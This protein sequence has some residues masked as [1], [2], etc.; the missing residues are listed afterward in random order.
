MKKLLFLLLIAVM[1]CGCSE[2]TISS[3]EETAE[4]TT[5]SEIQTE[6]ETTTAVT[7]KIP[8]TTT[9]TPRI[10]RLTYNVTENGISLKMDGKN[11]QSIELGYSPKNDYI[12]AADFDFDGYQDIFIPFEDSYRDGCYYRYNP[13]TEQFESWDKLDEI[14]YVMET[15]GN[16]T[17][18]LKMYSM[19]GEKYFTYKWTN[20]DPCPVL[21]SHYYYTS[22]GAVDDY[23]EYTSDGSRI[24]FERHLINPSNGVRYK[25]Y[26]RDELVYFS[27]KANGIDVLRDGKV[28]QTIEGD[29]LCELDLAAKRVYSEM[30]V[31]EIEYLDKYGYY[32]PE[33]FLKT[34][35]FDFDGFDDLFIPT[36]HL[37]DTGVYYRFDPKT[38][39]FYEWEELNQIGESVYT[40][41]EDEALIFSR[42]DADRREAEKCVYQWENDSLVRVSRELTYY[43][44]DGELYTDHFDSTDTLIKREH[45]L[46]DGYSRLNKTEEVEIN[47][48]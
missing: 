22:E 42:Y 13:E 37:S 1:L 44:E 17:L 20:G 26:T 35:D 12:S 14:G 21:L 18:L 4:S 9:T 32:V 6:T 2:N 47:K 38:E 46:F 15:D 30:P 16:D 27:V 36:N 7:T 34:T 33:D 48:R 25:T 31:K 10:C 39:C 29:Y 41:N 19:T 40:E 5:A 3:S 11:A 23:Y 8:E 28:L 45:L 43:G 24:L